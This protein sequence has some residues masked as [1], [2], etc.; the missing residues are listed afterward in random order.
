[1]T[2]NNKHN[3]KPPQTL[4]L[5]NNTPNPDITIPAKNRL[6][7]KGKK[8]DKCFNYNIAREDYIKHKLELCDIRD[9][10]NLKVHQY[11]YLGQKSND[12]NW[13]VARAEY[14][15]KANALMED[16][17]ADTRVDEVKSLNVFINNLLDRI[18]KHPEM[19]RF[20]SS[21]ELINVIDTSIK[22]RELLKGNDT[23]RIDLRGLKANIT[24][25][26]SKLK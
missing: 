24:N 20:R 13:K 8:L 26:I 9:K 4:L 12:D 14:W 2:L 23:S 18:Q 7:N 17:V 5:N 16:R 6:T 22:L 15:G 21:Q 11:K 1:M 3:P 25:I 19:F 10:Y